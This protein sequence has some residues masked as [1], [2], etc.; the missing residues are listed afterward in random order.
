M[1]VRPFQVLF[2]CDLF[3]EYFL[4]TF[5]DRAWHQVAGILTEHTGG[6]VLGAPPTSARLLG[7]SPPAGASLS[8][9]SRQ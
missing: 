7:G 4:A 6:P 5:R 3:S 1:A 9:A 8:P 2:R